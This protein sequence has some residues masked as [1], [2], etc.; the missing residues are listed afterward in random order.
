MHHARHVIGLY[1]ILLKNVSILTDSS[2]WMYEKCVR[3]MREYR[4][5][6]VVESDGKVFIVQ[7]MSRSKDI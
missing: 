4:V 1:V 6:D 5:R 3:A 2:Q 7:L